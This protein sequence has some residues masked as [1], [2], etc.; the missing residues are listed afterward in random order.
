MTNIQVLTCKSQSTLEAGVQGV[1]E[2]EGTQ[3]ET[4]VFA[5]DSINPSLAVNHF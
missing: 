5:L 3:E 2:S 4:D 1:E